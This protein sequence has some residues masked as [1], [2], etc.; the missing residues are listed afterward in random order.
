VK[1]DWRFLR[2]VAYLYVG[3]TVVGYAAFSRWG[4]EELLRNA[5]A[6]ES[7]SLLNLLLGYFAIEYSFNKSNITFLKIVLGG[8]G[9]RLFLM[10]GLVLVLIRYFA[11]DPL[12]LTLSLLFFYSLNLVLEIYL[13]DNKVA[14]KNQS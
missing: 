11:F 3:I 9:A 13:L 5:I 8:M 2:L 4:T 7:M 14:V 12:S 6:A 10:A 1:T